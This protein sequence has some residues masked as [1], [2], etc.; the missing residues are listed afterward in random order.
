MTSFEAAWAGW[1][2]GL[3]G[4]ELAQWFYAK[5]LRHAS[6]VAYGKGAR[7]QQ[8][9]ATA[10]AAVEVGD[11]LADEAAALHSQNLTLAAPVSAP[12]G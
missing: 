9:V 6:E 8:A 10:S 7:C 11:A 5:A 3:D 12:L 1:E 2:G 4:K